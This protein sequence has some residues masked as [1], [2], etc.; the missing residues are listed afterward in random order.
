[1]SYSPPK[2][3]QCIERI[4]DG[5]IVVYSESQSSAFDLTDEKEKKEK[6]EKDFS[7]DLVDDDEDDFSDFEIEE[8]EPKIDLIDRPLP[9]GWIKKVTP[10][11]NVLY[12]NTI[13]NEISTVFPED[14]K[15]EEPSVN[16]MLSFNNHSFSLLS[17]SQKDTSSSLTPD[18]LTSEDIAGIFDCVRKPQPITLSILDDGQPKQSED[19]V[20]EKVQSKLK[21][22]LFPHQKEAVMWML[23]HENHIEYRGGILADDMGCGK[24][25]STI[26][27]MLSNP[28]PKHKRQHTLLVAPLSL[29]LQWRDQLRFHCKKH[30]LSK[31]FVHHGTSRL[32]TVEDV[33]KYDIIFT[34]YGCVASELENKGVLQSMRWYRVILDEAH[35]VK[36]RVTNAY[37][38]VHELKASKRWCLT[39]T[40]ILNNLN[41]IHSLFVFLRF[42]PYC[43]NSVSNIKKYIFIIEKFIIIIIIISIGKKMY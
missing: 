41:D 7:I 31:S 37:K 36:N 30:Q 9:S 2:K 19:E 39:G 22:T 43:S 24:T 42:Q 28:N 32:K 33:R 3:K 1:M 15:N 25:L 21:T 20:I 16:P 8:P 23:E 40:P 6:K 18:K 26:A 10:K 27:L 13:T 29:I 14:P 12:Q 5:D 4:G 17:S 38:G 35:S 11:G 34:T